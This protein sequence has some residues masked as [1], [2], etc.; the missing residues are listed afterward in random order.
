MADPRY[1]NLEL[2]V[3]IFILFALIAI[4]ALIV[5][6][7]IDKGLFTPK[8][9]V[10]VYSHTGEGINRGMPVN[11][12]GFQISRV[13]DI[14]LLDDGRVQ[15]TVPIPETYIRWIK[16]SSKFKLESQNIIGAS[17]ITVSTDLTLI[18]PL[19]ANGDE[20][21][22]TK[23]KGIAEIVAAAIPVVDDLR[24]I[25]SS[26]NIVMH[27][28][29]ATDG[30]FNK[31]MKG[32]ARLGE[33]L[34]KHSNKLVDNTL[35]SVEN[36]NEIS[37]NLKVSTENSKAFVDDLQQTVENLNI[38]IL[39]LQNTWPISANKPDNINRIDLR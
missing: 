21:F 16:Q 11:Y 25:I 5:S 35:S 19:V 38:L 12:A 37:A 24:E 8:I 14:K 7:G 27:N 4:V 29:A 26:I 13:E 30:D 1:K 10:Y 9:T 36:I 32:A 23:D 15:M 34:D 39:Q 33:N 3:G 28:F 6:I 31:F 22:L 17:I 18:S 20:F 2:K